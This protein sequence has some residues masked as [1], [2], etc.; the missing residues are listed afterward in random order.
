MFVE[1]H[2][3][4]LQHLL[5]HHLQCLLAPH[6]RRLRLKHRPFLEKKNQD[7]SAL[8][9]TK[10]RPENLRGWAGALCCAGAFHSVGKSMGNPQKNGKNMEKPMENHDEQLYLV[11]ALE[12]EWILTFHSVGNR[13]IPT[14]ELIFFRGVGIPPTSSDFSGV[15]I[16][17]DP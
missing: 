8:L 14:D 7:R 5:A 12:H 3:S 4:R 9:E 13:K 17:Y 2:V 15:N 10:K 11:G 6:F 1:F 16:D